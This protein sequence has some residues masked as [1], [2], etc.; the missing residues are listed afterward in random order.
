[1]PPLRY[2]IAITLCHRYYG[3]PMAMVVARRG[4]DFLNRSKAAGTLRLL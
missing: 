1:M 2:A 4:C 3:S